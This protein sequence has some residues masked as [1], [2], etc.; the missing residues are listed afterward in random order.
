MAM[1]TSFKWGYIDYVLLNYIGALALPNK[2]SL[3]LLVY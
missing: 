1:A 2:A 3:I